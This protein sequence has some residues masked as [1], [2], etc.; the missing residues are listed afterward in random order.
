MEFA[1]PCPIEEGMKIRVH[2]D[3]GYVGNA[4]VCRRWN[5]TD[6]TLAAIKFDDPLPESVPVQTYQIASSQTENA[7]TAT[8]L[9]SQ[10]MLLEN[11]LEVLTLR[12]DL[13][14]GLKHPNIR[15]AANEMFLR[16]Y[17]AGKI[18]IAAEIAEWAQNH[19]WLPK[20]AAELGALAQQVSM[21]NEPF[22]TGGPWWQENIIDILSSLA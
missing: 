21:G 14:T 15:N 12:A 10:D 6:H 11:A 1:S 4:I 9:S 13:S 2:L 3:L 19:G 5:D 18:L 20:D 17:L 22:I 7:D 16:L 8:S